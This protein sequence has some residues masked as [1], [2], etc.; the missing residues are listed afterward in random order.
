MSIFRAAALQEPKPESPALLFRDLKG[1]D[2]SIKFLWEHQGK[3]LNDYQQIHL[4][5]NDVAV[6]LPT[7]SGKT[8]VGMLIGEYRRRVKGERVVLL[9]PN[10]QLCCQVETQARKYGITTSLLIG[11]QKDYDPVAFARYQQAKAIAIS[12]YSGVFNSNPAINDSQTIICDDAHAADGF[13]AAMWTLRVDRTEEKQQKVFERL[14]SALR[15]VVPA[16]LR[17]LIEVNSGNP[18]DKAMVDLVPS[19]QAADHF[20]AIREAMKAA[21]GTDLIHPWRALADNLEGC[22]IYCSP[23]VIE[24]RPV[25]PPTMMHAPFHRANQRVYMSAT[26]GE[27]GDIERAFG[28]KK[29]ARL[30]MPLG[31]EKRGTGRRLV[32]FPNVSGADPVEV[33]K[34]VVGVADRCLV[35][36]PHGPAAKEIENR[37][38]GKFKILGPRDVEQNI[39]VFTGAKNV[40]LVMANRYDGL[41]LPGADC[42]MLAVVGLPT[43][44]SLQERYLIER[45]GAKSQF[46]DRIRTR[47]TQ[48]MGRCTRD[49]GDYSVVLF[50]APDLLK[51][52]CTSGNVQGIH[53]ELQAEIQFGLEESENR[54]VDD[55]VALAK[56]FLAQSNEWREVEKTI[57]AKR[58]AATK[59]KD[60][61]TEK[62]AKAAALEIDFVYHMWSGQYEDALKAAVKV[63]EVLEGGAD[64]KPYRSFWYELAA[65]A[66]FHQYRRT[67]NEAFREQA[68]ARTQNAM[69][70]TFG[71]KWAGAVLSYLGSQAAAEGEELPSQEWFLELSGLLEDVGV[72]G[73]K[74][75]KTVAATREDIRSTNWK[76]FEL[77]VE[78]FGRM[79]GAKTKRFTGSGK[80]DG[81]WLFGWWFSTVFEAKTMEAPDAGISMKTVGQAALH[82]Q[83]VRSLGLLPKDVPCT[84]V[85]VSPRTSVHELAVPHAGEICYTAHDEM[86]RLFDEAADA[87]THVRATAGNSSDEVLRENF[88]RVYKERKLFLTDIRQRLTANKLSALSV[89]K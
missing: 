11:P 56:G 26:L 38:S 55:M 29:I 72:V 2:P 44:M 34:G 85:I 81:F 10:K 17:R 7:G 6:E 30:P 4:N 71:L 60:A 59:V 89:I 73:G 1:K 31:W 65:Q 86:G 76:R 79:L 45:L 64:L 23:E 3:L 67:R 42:R 63:T 32:L 21:E 36:V 51:W 37:L 84:T 41:D 27:N 24:I 39:K 28:V 22:H 46:Q 68:I 52:C 54:S 83:T 14:Y 75:E 19:V 20:D 8:L 70:S 82:E 69:G 53:P 47:T 16:W 74:F 43:G 48:A 33:F 62:L 9:C 12:T 49:E 15:V 80:P 5:D 87:F 66:A 13:V 40:A 25:I 77:G 58:D 35:L 18:A 88:I 61:T 78:F 50:M 57:V